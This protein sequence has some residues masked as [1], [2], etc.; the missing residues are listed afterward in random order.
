MI[1]LY[2]VLGATVLLVIVL[3][4]ALFYHLLE[5]PELIEN[6]LPYA[7]ALDIENRWSEQ[8]AETLAAAA[9]AGG[10]YRPGWYRGGALSG[11]ISSASL[12]PGSSSGSG[13][14]W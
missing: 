14:G 13:G 3:A 4:K 2:I 1:E 6:Y 10:G 9:G 8:V 5:T 11:A 12:A 7:L